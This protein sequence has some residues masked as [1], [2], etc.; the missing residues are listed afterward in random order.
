MRELAD[1]RVLDGDLGNYR[2][3]TDVAE[4]RVPATLQATLTSRIDRVKPRG[5]ADPERRRG[6]RVAV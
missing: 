2:C 3:A 1:R 4:V 6:D 5:E